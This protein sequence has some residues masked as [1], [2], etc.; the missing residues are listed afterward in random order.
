MRNYLLR[1]IVAGFLFSLAGCYSETMTPGFSSYPAFP[2]SN[3]TLVQSVQDALNG[4]GD[5]VIAQV[6]VET[7]QNNVVLTGYVKKIRQS[8]VAEQIAHKVPGVQHVDNNIIV[9]Q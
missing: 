4:S 1:A 2:A 9:R 7:H 6:H 5:P 3:V 8:D